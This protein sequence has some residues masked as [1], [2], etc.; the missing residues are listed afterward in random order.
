MSYDAYSKL[1]ESFNNPENYFD[2]KI[3]P[4]IGNEHKGPRYDDSKNLI[5]HSVVC[6]KYF[7]KEVLNLSRKDRKKSTV[8]SHTDRKERIM[9]IKSLLSQK[10]NRLSPHNSFNNYSPKTKN[11]KEKEVKNNFEIITS[12]KVHE[13]YDN[14]ESRI[15]KRAYKVK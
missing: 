15:E 13:I 3:N 10:V 4:L 9:Q 12:S 14:I 6:G 11:K 2:F 7:D 1:E 8:V 5:S